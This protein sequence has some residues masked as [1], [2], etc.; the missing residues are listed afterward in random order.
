MTTRTL[1]LLGLA[2]ALA[3]LRRRATTPTSIADLDQLAATARRLARRR[4]H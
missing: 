1:A 2:A 3:D 4:A